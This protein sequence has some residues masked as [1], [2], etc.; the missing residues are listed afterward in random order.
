MLFLLNSSLTLSLPHKKK[1]SFI[2]SLLTERPT[3]H[4]LLLYVDDDIAINLSQT[5]YLFASG[6]ISYTLG[7]IAYLF[8]TANNRD[9]H[10][11]ILNNL[12]DNYD[13]LLLHTCL[14]IMSTYKAC[15]AE[16]IMPI[17]VE[18]ES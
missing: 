11:A 13:A 14:W 10:T 1:L 12:V 18:D 7:K 4:D 6:Y 2:D 15:N 3:Q 16:R 5:A 8:A 17:F 9:E